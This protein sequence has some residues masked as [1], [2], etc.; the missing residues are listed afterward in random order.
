MLT[1]LLATLLQA[2]SPAPAGGGDDVVLHLGDGKRLIGEVA[3][4]TEDAV[5]LDIGFDILK[6]PRNRIVR[7]ELAD[8]GEGSGEPADSG[9]IFRR[10]DLPEVSIREGVARVG[11]A[12]VKIESGAGQGSG[13]VTSP[14]GYVVTNFHVVDGEVAVDVTLYLRSKNGFDVRTVKGCKVV[15]INP[16]ID[17]ALVKMEPP[18]DV[19]LTIAYIGDS[20]TVETGDRV[21]AIGTPIGLERSVSEGIVS[22]TN[23]SFRGVPHFQIT[24]AINPGNSGG[25][26]FDLSGRVVGVANAKMIGVGIEGLNFSIPGKYLVDFL[27]NRD[28]FA[29]DSTRSEHGIHY[30]PAPT[31]PEVP[32]GDGG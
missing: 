32:P 24:A 30:L 15:A 16:H 26:L 31:K 1:T 13:F 18:D 14:D 12:V 10:A 25:P 8:A 11:E 4:E 6:V 7:R 22:V 29:F 27:R 23:R 5:F 21:Y 9:E 17:L 19:E 3:K 2:A 28:A 20:E